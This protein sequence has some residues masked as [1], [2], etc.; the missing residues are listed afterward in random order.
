M[1][2]HYCSDVRKL[3]QI[4]EQRVCFEQRII[5]FTGDNGYS[6]LMDIHVEQ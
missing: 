4:C 5:N 3:M 1:I 2:I 6:F